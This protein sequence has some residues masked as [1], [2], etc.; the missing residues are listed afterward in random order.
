MPA[1][2]FCPFCSGLLEQRTTEGRIRSCCRECGKILYENPIPAAC[3]LVIDTENRLLLV[4]RAV[5]PKKG[6]WCLPGGFMELEESPED[7]A[8]RELFEE[9][10]LRGKI[11]KLIGVTAHPSAM[12]GAVLITGFLIR[13]FSGEPASGDDAMDLAFF[14]MTALPPLAF[15]SHERFVRIYRDLYMA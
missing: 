10:G 9:T 4:R 8:L 1:K 12:Y 5:P 11:H 2:K 7:T 14:P 15:D 13:T 6:E 3:T